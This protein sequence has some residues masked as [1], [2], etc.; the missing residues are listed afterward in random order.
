MHRTLT[1]GRPA[2]LPIKLHWSWGVLN[3]VVLLV[4]YRLYRLYLPPPWAWTVALGVVLLLLASVMLHEFGH[5][6]VA[7]RYRMPVQSITLFG[8]GGVTEI[9]GEARNPGQELLIA[10]A[11]PIV[12][13]VLTLGLGLGWWYSGSSLAD[14]VTLH[15][16]LTNGLIVVVNLLPSYPL[17][18]GRVLRAVLWFLTGDEMPA[19]RLAARAG[20]FCGWGLLGL[21]NAYAL[22][23]GD[24]VNALWFGLLGYFMARTAF[25]GYRRLTIQR[26]LNGVFVADIMQRTYRAVGPDMR[27]DHFVGRF[28]LGQIDQSYP[29]ID[30]PGCG[31]PQPLLGMISARNLRRFEPS[32]WSSTHVVEVMT[33]ASQV[34]RLTL[35]TS[36]GDA[37]RALLESGQEQLPVVDGGTLL[38]MLRRRDL[39]QH[40]E[41]R[42][43]RL[44]GKM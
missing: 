29:V 11:G 26:A 18:G 32:R 34:R 41:Q 36:A 1:I 23:S 39:A 44:G 25:T 24:L 6:L 22:T 30:D 19:T 42:L 3:A 8:F 20:Q 12:S 28:V 2:G 21:A 14:M 27:L 37:F 9:V 7:L 40:L 38:G 31:V 16:A 13:L 10:V 5:A 4:L 15:L 17:D 33:P 35:D 43:M